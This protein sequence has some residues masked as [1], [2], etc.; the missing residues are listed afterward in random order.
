[1]T[2]P[3]RLLPPKS[4]LTEEGLVPAAKL[5]VSWK[6][7][8]SP[9]KNAPVGSYLEPRLFAVSPE[10]TASSF[11]SAQPVVGS[12]RT[13]SSNSNAQDGT[14]EGGGGKTEKKGSREEELLKRM[15]GGKSGL[16]GGGA[17][18]KPAAKD[19]KD[20]KPPNGG[21]KPKWFK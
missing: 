3:R 14:A 16:G 5:F 20:A 18:K 2:P 8:S 19:P 7:G 15:M 12:D 17:A 10:S 9:D 4:T 6:D 11:P 1:V 21:G 13:S